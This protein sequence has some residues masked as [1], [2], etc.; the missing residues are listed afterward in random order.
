MNH[1]VPFRNDN[2]IEGVVLKRS[3]QNTTYMSPLPFQRKIIV[4]KITGKILLCLF[5][6]FFENMDNG[7]I[8][9]LFSVLLAT[10]AMV[11]NF[12]ALPMLFNRVAN[13]Q[14]KMQAKMDNFK[15]Q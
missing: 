9:A 1:V 13:I 3:E 12:I 8:A 15:V 10:F 7:R 11:I 5:I 4:Y 2:V 14:F 6:V